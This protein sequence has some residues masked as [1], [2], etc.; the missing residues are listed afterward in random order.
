MGS[1]EAV[2][3]RLA[4]VPWEMH[5][6][7]LARLQLL[8]YAGVGGDCRIRA[9]YRNLQTEKQKSESTARPA[10]IICYIS[11]FLEDFLAKISCTSCCSCY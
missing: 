10:L 2:G 5:P 9:A 7:E 8:G 1:L 6:Q 3:G 4:E 11:V